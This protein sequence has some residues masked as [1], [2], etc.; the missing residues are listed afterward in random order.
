MPPLYSNLP[1]SWLQV[2][3]VSERRGQGANCSRASSSK[4]PHNVSLVERVF[5]NHK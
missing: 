1:E 3:R 4:G 5:M 2:S